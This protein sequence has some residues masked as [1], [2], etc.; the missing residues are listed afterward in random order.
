M[1]YDTKFIVNF[2]F[3]CRIGPWVNKPRDSSQ[4]QLVQGFYLKKSWLQAI[5]RGQERWAFSFFRSIFQEVHTDAG[6]LNTVVTDKPKA[7]KAL[8]IIIILPELFA[9]RRFYLGLQPVERS[10]FRSVFSSIPPSCSSED[11]C[12][13]CCL[14]G[15]IFRIE[16]SLLVTRMILIIFTASSEFSIWKMQFYV[17]SKL[18]KDQEFIVFVLVV[19]KLV[20]LLIFP[21]KVILHSVAISFSKILWFICKKLF[22]L[23]CLKAKFSFEFGFIK[24]VIEKAIVFFECR[25]TACS[26]RRLTRD[27]KGFLQRTYSKVL[28]GKIDQA[29]LGQR[30]GLDGG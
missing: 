9:R 22:L 16:N 3:R 5:R 21:R 8:H 25:L 19:H 4:D 1:A 2:L 30:C 6:D 27:L 14:L 24:A 28:N 26:H 13:S 10:R 17:L 11:L 15:C 20:L 23:L 29:F 7:I 12:G 18:R